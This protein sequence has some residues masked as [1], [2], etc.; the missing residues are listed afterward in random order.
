M[1]CAN[2]RTDNPDQARFCFN[3]GTPFPA[4]CAG[5]QAPLQPGEAACH[6]CGRPAAPTA[7]DAARH[8]RLAAAAPTPLAEKMRAAHLAGER[9]LV[10]VLFLD[11]VGSTALA[12]PLD[13]EDWTALM[14]RAFDRLSPVIYQYEGTIARLMGDALLAFFGAPVTHEDDPVRAVHAALALL[15]AAQAYSR[16]VQARYGFPFSVRIGLNTGTVVVGHV[17]SDLKYEYT[18]MGDAVNLAA[19]LQAAAQPN[20][21]LISDATQR[22]IA[23]EFECRD[24]GTLAVKGKA[25]P[26]RVFEVLGAR[27][28]PA[29]ARGLG[30]VMSPLV[31]RAPELAALLQISTALHAGQGC[32]ALVL[33]EPGLG[34]SRLLAEW[35][36]AA[37]AQGGRSTVWAQSHAVSFGRGLPYHLVQGLLRSLLRVPPSAPEA[38]TRASLSQAVSATVG[39]ATW[40]EVFPHLAHLL[41]L[42]LDGEAEDRVR[43]AEASERPA[44]AA[45]ALSRLLAATASHQPLV[46]V[47]DDIHWADASSVDLLARLLPLARTAPLAWCLATRPEPNAPGWRLVTATREQLAPVL[48]ELSLAPLA[49][50]ESHQLIANLL[51]RPAL[52]A[53]L[54]DL[55]LA[56]AEGNPLFVEEV[57]RMLVERGALSAGAGADLAAAGLSRLEIPDNLQGLL[58]ARIDQLPDEARQALRVAA[59][60]AAAG[61]HFSRRVLEEVMARLE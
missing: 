41:G 6:Q 1:I 60:I 58:L 51:Q 35:Q 12:E 26:V 29:R 2:C 28:Q 54:C 33:G 50:P 45:S 22:F 32:A 16:D 39:E 44:M 19:R 43:R 15:A 4:R 42:P 7:V 46:I 52:P 30:G 37:R 34:K 18:A 20:T 56:R 9:K 21:V 38:E 8:A 61:R 5:C 25:A 31:G 40:L 3:C 57:V 14:N 17:G 10:T 48:T 49:E 27:A 23:A 53:Q 11:V 55:I 47:L 36:A 59:V 13:P 24:R